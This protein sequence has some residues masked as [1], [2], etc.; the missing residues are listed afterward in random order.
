MQATK[1]NW[2]DADKALTKLHPPVKDVDDEDD[3]VP[4]DSGSF[5]NLFEV[6][7]DAFDVST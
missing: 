3:D 7:E 2:K 1:I 4:S 6:E 5:F